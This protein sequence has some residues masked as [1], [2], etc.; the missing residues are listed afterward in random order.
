M[1]LACPVCEVPHPDGEHLAD[2]VA[3]T[4]TTRAGDHR[5]W[6]DDH[7]P[8]WESMTRSELADL[9][10]E[11]AEEVDSIDLHEEIERHRAQ[12]HDHG[13]QGGHDHSGPASHDHGGMTGHGGQPPTTGGGT[14][15][16]DEEA[17][18]IVAEARRMAE[19]RRSGDGDGE[20]D[21]NGDET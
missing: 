3:I 20:A 8:D 14:E 4:A 21:T 15:E 16:L 12:E 17:Q 10:T 11:Y 19:Q 13:G 5:A 2:H 9:V 6:L 18:A 1:G 7:A